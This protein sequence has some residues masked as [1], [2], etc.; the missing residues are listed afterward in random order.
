M[1]VVIIGS[2]NVATVLGRKIKDSG[3]TILQVISRTASHAN[4]LA[5]I[6]NST[7][8]TSLAGIHP[9]AGLCIIAVNDQQIDAVTKELGRTNAIIVHTSGSVSINA[10]QH[11]GNNYGVLYPLQTLNKHVAELPLIPM[12]V[13][14]NTEKVKKQLFEFAQTFTPVVAY[15]NDE[16]RLKTHLAAVIAN[17]FTN[18]LIALTEDFCLKEGVDFKLL[19]PL[20]HETVGRLG[21]HS[22]SILQ[23]GPAVRGDISTIDKHL[24]LLNH[25]PALKKLY[26][27]LTESI[28]VQSKLSAIDN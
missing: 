25:Q 23:T 27:K 16:K 12:I 20:I 26:L 10:L 11:T 18:H 21:N 8:T 2:G 17:N 9:A 5:T 1:K 28:I 22:P 15:A 6:L 7:S 14:G 3:A 4:Q 13:D 19:F 24:Q